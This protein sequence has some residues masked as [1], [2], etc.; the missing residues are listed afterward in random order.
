MRAGL[1]PQHYYI[2]TL[3]LGCLGQP[4]VDPSL[5]QIINVL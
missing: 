3:L 5:L 4:N 2:Y 1:K